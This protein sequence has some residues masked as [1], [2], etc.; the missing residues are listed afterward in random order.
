MNIFIFG[1]FF[2]QYLKVHYLWRYLRVSKIEIIV[3]VPHG[4]PS[5]NA[6]TSR[7]IADYGVGDDGLID[8]FILRD[9]C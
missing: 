6:R 1:S 8:S 7:I 3:L 2:S 9:S 5:D 4:I